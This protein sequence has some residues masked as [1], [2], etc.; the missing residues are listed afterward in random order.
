[1]PF[2]TL[3]CTVCLSVT[4]S[5]KWNP[6]IQA[7]DDPTCLCPCR[8][9]DSCCKSAVLF[10]APPSGL[11]PCRPSPKPVLGTA[12][13][14]LLLARG[15]GCFGS[16]SSVL[17]FFGDLACFLWP[18]FTAASW[19]SWSTSSTSSS[20][21][22]STASTVSQWDGAWDMNR[23]CLLV[24]RTPWRER[25]GAISRNCNVKRIKCWR[26]LKLCMIKHLSPSRTLPSWYSFP[27]WWCCQPFPR[28]TGRPG[29]LT[30]TNRGK[31]YTP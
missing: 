1:M 13:L 4:N 5:I 28:F 12:D 22:S 27:W 6:E 23:L 25:E 11:S 16:W 7:F 26:K 31:N 9:R 3:Q 8:G 24:P 2:L 30:R 15:L 14:R 29:R 18:G 10:S 21:A 17:V 20:K 19:G